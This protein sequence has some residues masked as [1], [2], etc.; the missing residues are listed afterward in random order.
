MSYGSPLVVLLKQIAPFR[1]QTPVA[2]SCEY[3]I[4]C[5]VVPNLIDLRKFLFSFKMKI[6]SNGI[7]FG[8]KNIF[9]QL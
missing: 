8:N 5:F 6:F 7:L 4:V 2:L 3:V 9:T 1:Y